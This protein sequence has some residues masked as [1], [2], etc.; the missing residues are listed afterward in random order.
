MGLIL[1][2]I[3]P[4][5]V[6]LWR[7][8]ILSLGAPLNVGDQ[9]TFVTCSWPADWVITSILEHT[10]FPVVWQEIVNYWYLFLNRWWQKKILTVFLL[11]L[12]RSEVNVNMDF[13]QLLVNNSNLQRCIVVFSE[14]FF[15]YLLFLNFFSLNFVEPFW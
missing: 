14:C 8:I 13:H 3:N 11:N 4:I 10:T 9:S 6:A 7:D 5:K 1:A 15:F 12:T 2:N